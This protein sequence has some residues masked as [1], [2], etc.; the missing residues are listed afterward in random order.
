[1]A[2]M[3]R[4]VAAFLASALAL[5]G[6][7]V[8]AP[9][10]AADLPIRVDVDGGGPNGPLGVI[11]DSAT[12]GTLPW[13]GDDLAALGWG[14]MR[15]YAFPGVRI[16]ADNPGFAIPTVQTW[17][18][19]GFD[20]RVFVIG[21]GDNDVG[22]SQDSVPKAA[23]YIDSML[24]AIGPGREVLWL[25]ITH[26]QASWQAAWNA[27]LNQVATRR[28]NLHIYDWA[29]VAAQHPDWVVGDGVH[30]TPTGYRQR[31]LLVAD[32]TKV[33]MQANPVTATLASATAAGPTS[34]LDPLDPVRVLDTRSAGGRLAA[35]GTATVDL[36]KAV[37]SGAAAAAVNLTVDGP[38]GDGYLTAWDCNGPPPNVSS[39][40][41]TAGTPRGAATV[42]GLS[43][44]RTFCVFSY[45]ATDLIVDVGGAY[46]AGHGQR[47]SPQAPQ[48]ILDTR[49]SGTPGAG[50]TVRVPVPAANG[51]VPSAVTVNLTATGGAQPGFLTAFPCGGTPPVVSNVNH[52]VGAAAANLVTVK[53]GTDGAFCVYSLQKVDVLV[54]LLGRWGADG[55]WYQ[56]ADPVRLL[57]TRTGAG[58]WLGAATRLQ[59]VSL[60]LDQV[61]GVPAEARAITGTVTAASTWG[62][63]FVSTWP[64]AATRPD[65]STLNY[66]NQQTVPN[67]TVVA[68]GDDRTACTA[69]LAPA[70][71]LFDLTGWFTT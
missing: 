59:A 52:G 55:L 44:T 19:Q 38:A 24:D 10:A 36:S 21:L 20:P 58:G 47:F 71:L 30:L 50:A 14:P 16:P 29:A 43:A 11:G 37:P 8:T 45:A 40:N 42:V 54:D 65:A 63:G 2:V 12:Q 1:M 48:R 4:I 13:I 6:L 60:P 70:Y 33:L 64:C 28:L 56:P 9:P 61:K 35:G 69:T 3:P 51:V 49:T 68:L 25:N 62:D 46:E 27:A 53:V 66:T 22:F 32:A 41:Y 23:A 31:S 5:A 34:G 26:P 39:L 18:A 7:A 67:A 57:D 17:R 15:L